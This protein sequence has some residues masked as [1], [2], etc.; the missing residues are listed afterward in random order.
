MAGRLT[1]LAAA[2]IGVRRTRSIEFAL[3]A[4]PSIVAFLTP[5]EHPLITAPGER[6]VF[7]RIE[8]DVE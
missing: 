7:Q 6:L 4:V 8:H 1:H 5:D 3:R 2:L